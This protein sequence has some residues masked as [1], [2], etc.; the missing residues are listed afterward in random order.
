MAL[1]NPTQD[2]VPGASAAFTTVTRGFWLIGSKF[3]PGE[4]A[5]VLGV[6]PDGEYRPITNVAGQ[7]CVSHS[8]NT[9][10][11]DA[12][13]GDYQIEKMATALAASV[14]YLEDVL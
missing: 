1:I 7:I 11:V 5:T 10:F 14:G 13:A 3:A 6:G 4:S 9:V 12:P 2:A 8:P